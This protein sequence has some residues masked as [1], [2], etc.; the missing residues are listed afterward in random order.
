M[1]ITKVRPNLIVQD[2][3]IEV[4]PATRKINF[5]GTAVTATQT[6]FGEV[7]VDINLSGSFQSFTTISTPS[8]TSPVADSDTDTLTLLAGSSK[9]S[10]TGDSTADSVTF[11]VVQS[12][13]DHGSIGGLSDDDHLQYILNAPVASSRNVITNAG[14]A[15]TGLTIKKHASQSAY[16]FE[17]QNSSG[18]R[19]L[20]FTPAGQIHLVSDQTAVANWQAESV[21]NIIKAPVFVDTAYNY[22]A[23]SYL[24]GYLSISQITLTGSGGVVNYFADLNIVANAASE[25]MS[26]YNSFACQPNISSGTGVSLGSFIGFLSLPTLNIGTGTITSFKGFQS[27]Y[28]LPTGTITNF[29]HFYAEGLGSATTEVGLDLTGT[30]DYAIRSSSNGKSHF[31]TGM[32][33]ADFIIDGDTQA[34]LFFLDA[35]TDRIGIGQS[36]PLA[37]LHIETLADASIGLIVKGTVSQTGAMTEWRHS[38]GTPLSYVAA[39]GNI[40]VPDEAYGAGWNASLEVPT[41][42]AIYDKIEAMNYWTTTGNSGLS[43]FAN[44]IGTTDNVDLNFKVNNAAVGSFSSAGLYITDNLGIGITPTSNIHSNINKTYTTTGDR[45]GYRT[46]LE[47]SNVDA[48]GNAVAGNEINATMANDACKI[49]YLYGTTGTVHNQSTASGTHVNTLAATNLNVINSGTT[50]T[51]LLASVIKGAITT[52]S[53]NVTFTSGIN[54]QFSKSGGT[55]GTHYGIYLSDCTGMAT[56][57]WAIA[58]DGGNSYHIGNIRIGS[59]TA[60]TVALDVTGEAKFSTALG[61]AS[62][63]TGQT[64]SQLAINA[65]SQLTTNGDILYHNGTNSTRLARGSTGQLLLST[66]STVAWTSPGSSGL[67]SNTGNSGMSDGTNNLLGTTDAI[68]IRVLANNVRKF[69][70]KNSA[71]ECI[72]MFPDGAAI[73]TGTNYGIKQTAASSVSGT[74]PIYKWLENSGV[75]TLNTNMTSSTI[76]ENK[77]RYRNSTGSARIL[78]TSSTVYSRPEYQC[79]D[80]NL[81]LSNH[82][83]VHEAPSLVA[84]VTSGTLAM[85]EMRNFYC[86]PSIEAGTV[87][88]MENFS[89]RASI[90]SGGT[91]TT[92]TSFKAFVANNGTV[93][94]YYGLHIIDTTATTKYGVVQ[95]GSGMHNLFAGRLR[96]GS[97]ALSTLYTCS[98]TAVDAAD[99]VLRITGASSQSANYIQVRDS[100]GADLLNFTTGGVLRLHGA[101]SGYSGLKAAATTTSV[102]YTL[103]SAD[104]SSGQVLQTNGSG[105]LSWATSAAS[106]RKYELTGGVPGVG[107]SVTSDATF[108]DSGAVAGF[109]AKSAGK[110]TDIAIH[111]SSARTAGSVIGKWMKNGV[112][113]TGT[114]TISTAVDKAITSSLSVT[115]AAGD[116]IQLQTVTSAFTPTGADAVITIYMEDT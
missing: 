43:S 69:T 45:V 72:E 52:T 104:G 36:S 67:W 63:G 111:L 33:D 55:V 57:P 25:S 35:S 114:V 71:L 11:D 58:S 60:P 97:T 93:G 42:N 84:A 62:G 14:A 116:I 95:A 40:V 96:I 105:T 37:R 76:L 26:S 94:T 20:G 47:V 110:V 38:S 86:I 30:L 28:L 46:Y 9:V 99:V 87:T 6:T 75:Y 92:L 112:V 18:T 109:Y 2:E 90:T 31:N 24:S 59:S 113:Q 27:G 23:T 3:G 50:G 103:P 48:S 13:L 78:T 64:T 80:N 10:I 22:D 17:L 29:A 82:Y 88:N 66:A 32:A 41:K 77:V 102:D 21:Y 61:I 108:N 101:T 4:D 68:D 39:D 34:N 12:N 73:N 98:I 8:G 1:S 91:V 85:T 65:L 74:T 5:K 56:T 115:Y 79:S 16:P 44:F 106:A 89:S 54:L 51:T 53:G 19:T 100:A 15:V 7:D 83:G 70:V 81:S 107:G 49:L